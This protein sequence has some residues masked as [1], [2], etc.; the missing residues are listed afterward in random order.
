VIIELHRATDGEMILVNS[1][2]IMRV[3]RG[4]YGERRTCILQEH[5]TVEVTE[6]LDEVKGKLQA[7]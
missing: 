5:G 3:F 2:F 7:K 1:D 6:T 4:S